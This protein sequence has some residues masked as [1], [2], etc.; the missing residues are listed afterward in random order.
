MKKILLTTGI[1]TGALV[2]WLVLFSFIMKVPGDDPVTPRTEIRNYIKEHI[3][4]EIKAQREKLNAYLSPEELKKVEELKAEQAALRKERLEM[5][6]NRKGNF[7]KRDGT[8]PQF[9]DEQRAMMRAHLMKREKIRAEAYPIAAAHEKEIYALIDDLDDMRTE[10]RSQM[11][12]IISKYR[13]ERGFGKPGQGPKP[14][15]GPGSRPGAGPQ[16]QGPMFTRGVAKGGFGPGGKPG[17]R[18]FGFMRINDPVNFLLFDPEQMEEML[19]NAP[20]N[21]GMFYPVPAGDVIKIKLQV[22]KASRVTIRLYDSQGNQLATILQEDKEAGTYNLE[23]NINDLKPGV[24]FY[25]IVI[26]DQVIKRKF[27][28]S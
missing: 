11:H 23:Y 25:E 21:T 4:P 20:Q 12:D 18:S 1:V 3:L 19:E 26:G 15:M 8:G 7:P 22:D 17:R 27:I 16:G 5:I 14:G 28:K 10:W 9:T 6:K 2:M 13:E 24:Y